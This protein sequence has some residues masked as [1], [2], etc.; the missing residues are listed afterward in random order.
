MMRPAPALLVVLAWA[1][2]PS[3]GRAHLGHEIARAERYLKLDVA[4]REARLVVSLTLGAREGLRVLEAAD[5]SGDG[6]VDEAERDAYLAQWADGLATEL[7]VTVD[8]DPRQL[9]WGEPYMDPIGRVR[10]VPVTVELVARFALDGGRQEVRIVD[11]MVRREVYDRTDVSFRVRDGATLIAS[12]AGEAATS[13]NSDLA[14]G[15]ELLAGRPVEITAIVEAPAPPARPWRFLGLGVLFVALVA[16]VFL[17]R[18]RRAR[19][20]SGGA[21]GGTGS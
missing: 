3:S 19:R 21:T 13:P 2:A 18:R 7:P 12:A 5:A 20:A 4:G 6:R 8:G 9:A 17:I 14:Y 1:A 16:F 11:R 10:A 15:P